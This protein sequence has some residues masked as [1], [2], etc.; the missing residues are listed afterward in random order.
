M[1]FRLRR[2]ASLA[3]SLL[4][5]MGCDALSDGPPTVTGR[6]VDSET[7][8]PLADVEVNIS[9]T[10]LWDT[11]PTRL[12]M[13]TSGSDGRFRLEARDGK[14][15]PYDL[16]AW[17]STRFETSSTVGLMNTHRGIERTVGEG[18]TDLGTIPL[19]PVGAVA[20][21]VEMSGFPDGL[22][23][24]ATPSDGSEPSETI[25]FRSP[26]EWYTAVVAVPAGVASQISYSYRIGSGQFETVDLG[27]VT[28]SRAEEE[29][30]EVRGTGE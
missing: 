19:Q 28:V 25:V 10:Y 4:F 3:M 5:L 23:I 2:I 11:F 14:T 22:S 26:S 13:A 6:F 27:T 16:S 21:R 7:G 30:I 29:T 24:R 9:E 18:S 1:S 20:L 8:E 12:G 17:V 15:S